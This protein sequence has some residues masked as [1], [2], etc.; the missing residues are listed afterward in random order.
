MEN[1]K[2]AGSSWMKA[3]L[4]FPIGGEAGAF[5]TS[6]ASKRWPTALEARAQFVVPI[7]NL[8]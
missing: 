2:V 1:D 5:E 7:S 8:T 3:K 4:I 6:A